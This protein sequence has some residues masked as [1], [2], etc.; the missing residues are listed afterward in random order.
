MHAVALKASHLKRQPWVAVIF[1]PTPGRFR[2]A[3]VWRSPEQYTTWQAAQ[4]EAQ[5]ELQ[6]RERAA[7]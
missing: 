4:A 2:G 3:E 1:D 6:R 7:A 5:A